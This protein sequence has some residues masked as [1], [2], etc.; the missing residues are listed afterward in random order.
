M[1]HWKVPLSLSL[2][3]VTGTAI[4]IDHRTGS[5]SQTSQQV[6]QLISVT[7]GLL[8]NRLRSDTLRHAAILQMAVATNNSGTLSGV[9]SLGFMQDVRCSYRSLLT[10]RH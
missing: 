2:S 4:F 8:L 10:A 5:Q 6:G 9:D 7:N 1:D 3:D